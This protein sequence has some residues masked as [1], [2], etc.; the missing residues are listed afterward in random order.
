MSKKRFK[1]MAGPGAN[2]DLS[3]VKY[4]KADIYSLLRFRVIAK[5]E[6][7]LITQ[8][9][10]VSPIK[11]KIDIRNTL[12][13][14]AEEKLKEDPVALKMLSTGV[15]NNPE[16]FSNLTISQRKLYRGLRTLLDERDALVEAEG[17]MEKQKLE[18]K[19]K[20]RREASVYMSR[21]LYAKDARG[22]YVTYS[23]IENNDWVFAN[24]ARQPKTIRKELR[25]L[26]VGSGDIE[27]AYIN[28]ICSRAKLIAREKCN[29][30]EPPYR[31]F[32]EL[33]EKVLKEIYQKINYHYKKNYKY[34]DGLS[35]DLDALKTITN[36]KGADIALERAVKALVCLNG[37]CRD[38]LKKY[39]EPR[40]VHLTEIA[41]RDIEQLINFFEGDAK[42]GRE[43]RPLLIIGGDPGSGRN[44]LIDDLLNELLAGNR[45]T[46]TYAYTYSETKERTLASAL[47]GGQR[48]ADKKGYQMALTELGSDEHD[49]LKYGEVLVL[50]DVP[51]GVALRMLDDIAKKSKIAVIVSVVG[52][53]EIPDGDHVLLNL[54]DSDA[55]TCAEYRSKLC[56]VRMPPHVDSAIVPDR[57]KVIDESLLSGEAL[58]DLVGNGI[59]SSGTPLGRLNKKEIGDLVAAAGGN[60][61]LLEVASVTIGY[62]AD[63]EKVLE[64][65]RSSAGPVDKLYNLISVHPSGPRLA[66]I[67]AL[68][69]FFPS[70]PCR[71]DVLAAP[72]DAAEGAP[73]DI[74]VLDAI[75]LAHY[76]MARVFEFDDAAGDGQ[77]GKDVYF[78]LDGELVRKAARGV[79]KKKLS[80]CSEEFLRKLNKVL[81]ALEAESKK[82]ELLDVCVSYYENVVDVLEGLDSPLREELASFKDKTLE[83]LARL[84][85]RAG[86]TWH[87]LK[88]RE[89]ILALRSAPVVTALREYGTLEMQYGKRT[90]AI[91]TFEKAL[92]LCE[93]DDGLLREQA[94]IKG[95]IG[96]TYHEM[97]KRGD[98]DGTNKGDSDKLVG[99]IKA[100]QEAVGLLKSLGDAGAS[101]LPS[102]CSTLA[103]SKIE[104]DVEDVRKEARENAEEACELI[105]RELRIDDREEFVSKIIND[106]TVIDQIL[107]VNECGGDASAEKLRKGGDGRL[108][109]RQAGSYASA[110]YFYGR[111][112]AGGD[113]LAKANAAAAEG[114]SGSKPADLENARKYE[115][116]ALK[117][118]RRVYP[119]GIM[120]FAYNCDSLAAVCE[121]LGNLEEAKAFS[122]E[123]WALQQKRH[124]DGTGSIRANYERIKE[125]CS[126]VSEASESEAL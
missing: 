42:K 72:E 103:N 99:A 11:K 125:K 20:P 90:D 118:R 79:A 114:G 37:D 41:P 29:D 2:T 3:E 119:Q 16:G 70:R 67:L 68:L 19:D 92:G 97:W 108:S 109:E 33:A 6:L 80:E 96:W 105:E 21:C 89:K 88:A 81:S 93:G 102:A 87:E 64:V 60:I 44:S 5:L 8:E 76:R 26:R 40:R 12:I 57:V 65:L 56:L 49:Y 34:G 110:L 95:Q 85:R 4:S 117:I 101:D 25:R 23:A 10:A 107:A 48:M 83:R 13:D 59:R 7:L 32:A 75:D 91:K 100:K 61:K 86:S 113:R 22:N 63:Y 62:S 122:E 27:N 17:E 121:A 50:R 112:L 51:A 73:A 39:K 77:E 71:I 58:K 35:A 69:S 14:E 9:L 55:E 45:I 78:V 66:D 53:L 43:Y 111:V 104:S 94:L 54:S 18:N 47:E 126:A 52:K 123:A 120:L 30:G 115:L 98:A 15:L 24:R 84:Y 106:D 31:E 38:S 74:R 1:A 46:K 36:G 124:G 82:P 28:D 116:A